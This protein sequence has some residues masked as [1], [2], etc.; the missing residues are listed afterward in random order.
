MKKIPVFLKKILLV[1]VLLMLTGCAFSPLGRV[2][3]GGAI[4]RYEKTPDSCKIEIT[5]SRD[6]SGGQ[7][8]VDENCAMATKTESAVGGDALE[9]LKEM[10]GSLR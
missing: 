1:I 9:I 8:L 5:S 4:Y 3:D 2:A 6:V 7:I 10:A